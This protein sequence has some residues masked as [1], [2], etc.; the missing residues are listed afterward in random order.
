MQKRRASA[1]D[2]PSVPAFLQLV[3]DSA[4]T[5]QACEVEGSPEVDQPRS[6]AHSSRLIPRLQGIFRG[7][8]RHTDLSKNCKNDGMKTGRLHRLLASQ[9]KLP[10]PGLFLEG[11]A[12]QVVG[13][14]V[15]CVKRVR[16]SG[17]GSG[18]FCP[19]VVRQGGH[20]PA[21]QG[22]RRPGAR[23]ICFNQRRASWGGRKPAS[24]KG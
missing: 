2:G 5:Q 4:V 11:A 7:S 20:P 16:L 15:L 8:D 1:E 6:R 13:R 9:S 3:V 23:R 17:P 21:G 14:R 22:N 24:T 19:A 12:H 10:Q 18:L